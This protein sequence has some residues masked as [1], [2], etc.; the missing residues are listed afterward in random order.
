MNTLPTE[1]AGSSIQGAWQHRALT[2]NTDHRITNT[3]CG[4]SNSNIGNV[5]NSYNTTINVGIEEESLRIQE[6]LSPLEPRKRHQDVRKC[7]LDGVGEWVLRRSEFESW[8]GG[9]EREGSVNPT[10][11][12]FGAQGVGKT[13]IRYRCVLREKG[14]MLTSNKISSLV[15]DTLRKR[16]RGQNIAVMFLYCDYQ[17]QKDQSA[18]NLI[19]SLVRQAA[20]RAP[21]IPGEIKS[22]FDESKKEDGDSLRLPDMVKLVVNVFGSFEV[23]YL[24]VDAVDEVLPQHR[25]DFF[26]ALQQIVQETPNVRLFLTGRPYIRAELNSHLT[27]GAYVIDIVVDQEDITRY[28][29]RKIDDND[30]QDPNLMTEDLKNHIMK[31]ML[32]KASEM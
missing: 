21:S 28:L 31:T 26:R 8:C 2:S 20:S 4:D 22:A 30:H 16:T 7:R 17:A 12:C 13:Y 25:L 1:N 14:T 3:I 18:V 27:E 10:L 29:S 15:I 5:S 11:L 32:G 23:V 24:S 19:G 6:W 9:R